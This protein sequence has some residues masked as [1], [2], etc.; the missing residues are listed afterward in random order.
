MAAAPRST[1]APAQKHG[2]RALLAAAGMLASASLSARGIA[3]VL[4]GSGGATSMPSIAATDVDVETSASAALPSEAA[5]RGSLAPQATG[6]AASSGIGGAACAAVF[7]VAGLALRAAGRNAR[8]HRRRGER[9]ASTA[10]AAA[11][12]AQQ[13][14]VLPKVD[15]TTTK[16]FR[17]DLM[18]SEQYFRFSKTQMEDA[19][20]IL[21][22]TSGSELVTR[23][24]KN[25]NRL[26]IG[27]VTFVLAESYGF[28]WGVER[29]LAMAY[30]ARKFFPDKNI[31][32][33]NEIIHNAVVNRD[34]ANVGM[35]FVPKNAQGE[36]DFSGIEPGD[37]V[38]LP[39]FGASVDEM[40]FLQSRNVQIV[41]T[42][43]PWVS[44][45]WTSVEKTKG[46]GH[47]VII[48]GK[49][50]HE[51]TI[52]TKSFADTYL[53]VK[54]MPEAEYVANYILQGGNRD[55]F[56]AKFKDAMSDG[57]DPDKDL[58][59]VGVANQ[60]TMLKGET[61]LIGR[62]FERV[63]IRKF[64]PQSVNDHYIS[65]NTIC[66]AT[67][68]RQDAMYKMFDAEY[69]APTSRLYAELE[70]EQVGVELMSAKNKDKLSSKAAEDAIRGSSG[71]SAEPAATGDVD[72]VVCV[73]GF[74]SSNTT[75]L[76]EI[77]QELG[78]PAYH[79]D[80]PVRIGGTSDPI[81]NV[82]QHKPLSTSPA[83]AMLEE[84]LEV[85]EGFL[86]KGPI[87]IGVTSGAS[88]PDASVGQCLERI[89]AIRGLQA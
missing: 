37:V 16:Q 39:A 73:G 70:G 88:T 50:G 9:S 14:T 25:G 84:G 29:T 11:P 76:I 75:H 51:E 48:H 58:D 86:P 8:Q 87:V 85:T 69:E 2:G 26:T 43:C 35:K 78:V 4:G 27:D 7:G 79:I 28:C 21:K 46:K 53:V 60:T 89:L 65:F 32:V 19:M 40:A 83:K 59:R 66:D 22:S 31:W 54:N 34:L 77:P 30:E 12:V 47:T 6:S 42:T 44:K 56:M 68:E 62:L 23:I 71:A 45:V 38:I 33:T 55:E 64:G 41:D 18:R 5:L 67:Q 20:E 57:F 15:R 52:A 36:K 13:V 24:R 74:N 63:M 1:E 3:F 81:E 72:L 49:H 61:D 10:L 80:C 82:I 17:K